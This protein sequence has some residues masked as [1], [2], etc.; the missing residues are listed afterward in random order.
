VARKGVYEVEYRVRRRDGIYRDFFVRG[1]PV[2]DESGGVREWVG[3]SIDI[4]ERKQ[5]EAKQAEQF[6]EL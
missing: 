2:F 4:T 1:V 6:N 3:S 5:A